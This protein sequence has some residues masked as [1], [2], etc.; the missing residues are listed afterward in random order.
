MKK[1]LLIRHA[2]SSWDHPGLS[3][4]Q[5]PLADRG[6]R[7]APT[8]GKRLV[9]RGVMP[10]LIL[11]SDAVRALETASMIAREVA[12]PISQIRSTQ[13][14]YHASARSML[15]VIKSIPSGI[16]TLFL[17]GHNPGMNDF[18]ALMGFEIENLPTAGQFGFTFDL[19]GWDKVHPKNAKFWFMDYP[20]LKFPDI[21]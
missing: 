21:L 9:K 17:V 1:V 18:T 2:K 12:Y 16:D 6:M 3:D 4:H 8:M 15:S 5:R 10:D 20:K 13:D 19:I 11:S 14:L 7:D